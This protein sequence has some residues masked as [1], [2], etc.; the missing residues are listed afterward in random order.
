MSKITALLLWLK[1][2]NG[3]YVCV[4]VVI[5]VA[6]EEGKSVGKRGEEEAFLKNC[7]GAPSVSAA[8]LAA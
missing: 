8:P 1:K 5:G 4:E 3:L 2:R 6:C 7:R